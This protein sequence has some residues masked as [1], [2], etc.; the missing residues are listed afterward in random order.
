MFFSVFGRAKNK[1]GE[2][3]KCTICSYIHINKWKAIRI[4]TQSTFRM[5][6]KECINATRNKCKSRPAHPFLSF[7]IPLTYSSLIQNHTH[8]VDL[9]NKQQFKWSVS[10]RTRAIN[11][12]LSIYVLPFHPLTWQALWQA[13]ILSCILGHTHICMHVYLDIYLKTYNILTCIFNRDT[14]VTLYLFNLYFAY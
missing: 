4:H 2:R 1:A 14:W 8:Y 11:G 13:R 7:S 6:Q 10:Q 12:Q 5:G 9:M 3:W